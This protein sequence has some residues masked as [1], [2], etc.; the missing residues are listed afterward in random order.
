[1]KIKEIDARSGES[2]V[3]KPGFGTTWHDL[4]TAIKLLL[5]NPTYMFFMLGACLH[6]FLLN[7]FLTF[8]PKYMEHQFGLT[9]SDASFYSGNIQYKLCLL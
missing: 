2:V 9:A 4:P 8:L 1:M 3:D 7:G 6:N 5:L